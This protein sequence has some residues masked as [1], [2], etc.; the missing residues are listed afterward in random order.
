MDLMT[1]DTKEILCKPHKYSEETKIFHIS[2]S[3][4]A[5]VDV[6]IRSNPDN[7]VYDQI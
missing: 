1:T 4:A 5:I 2:Y 3:C 7:V 6:I